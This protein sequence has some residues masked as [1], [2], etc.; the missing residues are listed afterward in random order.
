VILQMDLRFNLLASDGLVHL[1]LKIL[2]FSAP[3]AGLILP[4]PPA[5]LPAR[6][7]QPRRAGGRCIRGGYVAFGFALPFGNFWW[8]LVS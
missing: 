7:I 1:F 6:K 8:S 4:P 5:H 2:N 3:A